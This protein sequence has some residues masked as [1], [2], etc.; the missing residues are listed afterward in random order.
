MARLNGALGG[1]LSPESF[2]TS[3]I[4]YYGHVEGRP[5]PS[6]E[7]LDGQ[8]IDKA[9][10]LDAG[11]LDKHGRPYGEPEEPDAVEDDED[12]F[13]SEPDTG[14]ITRALIGIPSD[15]RETWLT[16]GQALHHE[17]AGEEVGFDLWDEWSQPSGK[18]DDADQRRVWE[19]F[20]SYVGK[21][22]TVGTLYRLAKKHGVR[23]IKF[24]ELRFL[25]TEECRAAPS[26]DYIV[27]GLIAPG[28][29]GCI[30]GAP[31]AGKSL[32]APHIGYQVALGESV[33]GM[34][35]K[36]G[37]VLYV[38]AEDSHGMQNRVAALTI[39]QG[40]A[41][42]FRLVEGVSN[43]LTHDSPDLGALSESIDEEPPALIIIDTLAMAFPGLEENDASS[44]GRV[45]AVARQLAKCG[46]AVIFV[47]HDTKAESSTPRG[48]SIFNGALDVA[49][50]VKRGEDAIVRG[51]LTKNRNGSADK[52][53]AFRI[54]TEELCEDEDGEP[55]SAALVEELKAGEAARV[56]KM[57]PSQREALAILKELDAVG[58]V[59]NEVW[60]DACANGYRVSQSESE[61]LRRDSFNRARRGLAHAGL[62]KIDLNG[63]VTTPPYEGHEA[64]FEEDD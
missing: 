54:G 2:T 32:I 31:G 57:P 7:L 21:P 39:R 5:A 22:I 48:H 60:A 59:T 33:F 18:Y 43:L 44:M 3:Q 26:R 10:H 41:Q 4:Y 62:I 42:L 19:S 6:V 12:G 55:I 64:I 25:T 28:D 23:T 63:N 15:A 53:I 17:F 16:V 1:I 29:V 37:K 50:H 61:K 47:H 58:P 14:R 36:L 52:D 40:H 56:K 30:F 46:A 51:R 24:G 49:I 38:A 27:K 34:R 11:A 13:L 45:V 8:P 35:T 9:G 20:G